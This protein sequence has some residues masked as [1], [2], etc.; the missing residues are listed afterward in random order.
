MKKFLLLFMALINAAVTAVYIAL[1]PYDEIPTH[2]GVNG[3][4][5][6][7]SSKWT[8]MI[9][10]CILILLGVFFAIYRAVTQDSETHKKNRRYENKVVGALFLFLLIFFWALQIIT[11]NRVTFVG[12]LIEPIICILI[13]GLLVFISNLLTKIKP[14]N[15]LGI[16]VGATLNSK[17]VWKKTHR[18]A[19]YL[20]VAGGLMMIILGIIFL[21]IQGDTILMMIGGI[22]MWAILAGIIPVI[23]AEVLYNREKKATHN[24]E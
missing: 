21:F 7:F 14:N 18:L 17:T 9:M 2:Y 23:Y 1:C 6:A 20:G 5:D 4:A 11:T 15:F 16:R 3:Y 22:F 13:G 12:N 8:L 19:A 24:L 10:P